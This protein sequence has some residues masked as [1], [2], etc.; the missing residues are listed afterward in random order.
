MKQKTLPKK[1]LLAAIALSAAICYPSQVEAAYDTNYDTEYQAALEKIQDG[2][3]YCI[4]T[5]YS[6]GNTYYLTTSGVLTS[7]ISLAG[8]FVFRKQQFAET[9][10]KI[11]KEYSWVIS[12]D[13]SESNTRVRFT[14]RNSNTDLGIATTMRDLSSGANRQ[15]DSQ[16]LYYSADE[17]YAIRGTNTLETQWSSNRFWSVKEDNSSVVVYSNNSAPTSPDYVWNIK[18]P[19]E[20]N[21]PVYKIFSGTYSIK[22]GDNL[23]LI[24]KEKSS[25]HPESYYMYLDNPKN[26]LNT[27]KKTTKFDEFRGT[28]TIAPVDENNASKGVRIYNDCGALFQNGYIKTDLTPTTGAVFYILEDP[29]NP[30]KYAVRRATDN[31]YWNT[32]IDWTNNYNVF[33]MRNDP[34]YSFEFIN[35]DELFGLL[36][37]NDNNTKTE[38]ES[39]HKGIVELSRS[40]ST[41]KW[42]T[43]CLPFS[44]TEDQVKSSFGENTVI[45]ELTG[46]E[47]TSL[48]FDNTVKTM[49]ANKPYLV[50]VGTAA[51]KYYF[52]DVTTSTASSQTDSK[53]GVSFVGAFIKTDLNEG[54]YFISSNTIYRSQG[55]EDNKDYVNPF[56][57]FF[58]LDQANEAKTLSLN[59]GGEVTGIDVIED[60]SIEKS[61][62]VYD[63]SGR[64]IEASKAKHGLYII[65]GKK[66]IF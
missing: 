61:K 31:K 38:F 62:T 9:T 21:K 5:T 22:C 45:A 12:P 15:F 42:A 6:D 24:Q 34:L 8:E 36:A 32:K 27:V 55:L 40:L 57:G 2:G 59:M 30:G 47:G 48:N 46:L 60:L 53:N 18:T 65:N 14:N 17:K 4:T 52:T 54:D 1:S 20:L 50:K 10:N 44:L 35:G 56:R 33:N 7:D 49:D 64:Q 41:D 11:V 51:D 16:V 25:Q 58:R 3:T 39:E 63:L 28:F 13:N 19:Q 23:Y 43:L 26:I 29:E 37:L 66:V